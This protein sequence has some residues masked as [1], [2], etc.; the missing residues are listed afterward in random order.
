MTIDFDVLIPDL[1]PWR[2]HNGS[3]LKLGSGA[4]GNFRMAIGYSRIF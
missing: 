1:K 2:E 4:L 3:V